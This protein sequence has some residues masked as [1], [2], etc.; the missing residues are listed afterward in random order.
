MALSSNVM[1]LNYQGVD[2]VHGVGTGDWG[3]YITN[4][5]NNNNN[6]IRIII[7]ELGKKQEG[8]EKNEARKREL[9]SAASCGGFSDRERT[10]RGYISIYRLGKGQAEVAL[11]SWPDVTTRPWADVHALLSDQIPVEVIGDLLTGTRGRDRWPR[12]HMVCC[13]E[14]RQ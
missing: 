1:I 11:S 10:K 3:Q 2:T 7:K 14:E 9:S 13:W 5:N 12:D 6:I 4:N 8:R